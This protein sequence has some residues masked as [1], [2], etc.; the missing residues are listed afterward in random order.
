MDEYKTS[1][2]ARKGLGYWK[3]AVLRP[4]RWGQISVA[5]R[6]EKVA[7]VGSGRFAN[8]VRYTAANIAPLFGLDE[9]FTEGR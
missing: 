8:L 2:G 4:T 3:G 1:A 7:A 5:V 9:Q 6:K